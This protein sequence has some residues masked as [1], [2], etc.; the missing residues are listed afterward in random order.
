MFYSLTDGQY[1]QEGQAFTINDVQYPSNWLNLST[2]EEKLAIGLEEVIA[3]N[4][5]A[6]DVYYW[7]SSIL[8]KATLTYTNTPKDLTSVKS[9]A[10]STINSTAYTILQPSDWMV[11][12]ATETSTPIN[13]DWNTYRANVRSTADQTRTAVTAAQDVDAVATIM[14]AIVWPKSPSQVAAEASVSA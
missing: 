3:T 10:L 5:P 2:P 4:S 9:G 11:V 14:G 7:V 1:I 12:K 13:P 6:S 8:D